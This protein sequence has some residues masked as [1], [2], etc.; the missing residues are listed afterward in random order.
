MRRAILRD[1]LHV[2]QLLF[3][4]WW[5]NVA[6]HSPGDVHLVM[7]SL[8]RSLAGSADDVQNRWCERWLRDVACCRKPLESA[9]FHT[10]HRVQCSLV[11]W[12]GV[13]ICGDGPTVKKR[14]WTNKPCTSVLR[15][16][17]QQL[18][19]VTCV[20]DYSTR[21][22]V[23]IILGHYCRDQDYLLLDESFHRM[24]PNIRTCKCTV[25]RIP[26]GCMRGIRAVHWGEMH[27]LHYEVKCSVDVC[28][29]YSMV[30]FS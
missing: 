15:T 23:S 9:T 2:L 13:S 12:V 21:V 30:H 26:R 28:T 25:D 10:R 24:R 17:L 19:R 27:Y 7:Y 16:H 18:K 22:L 20:L 29:V 4:R 5:C 11:T 3:C 8:A 6:M 1:R 14:H